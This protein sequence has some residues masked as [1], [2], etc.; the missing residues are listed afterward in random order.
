MYIPAKQY[1]KKD[2]FKS[3]V[4]Y[5]Y[6]NYSE[7]NAKKIVNYFIGSFG[8]KRSNIDQGCIT[9][10]FQVACSL[11]FQ[12]QNDH[13][14]SIDTMN[15]LHFVR[16][17]N[18]AKLYNNGLS[19]HR[20]IICGGIINLANLYYSIKSPTV[21]II[22]FNTDSIMFKYGRNDNFED[23]SFPDCDNTILQTIGKIRQEPWKIKAR[24]IFTLED[25]KHEV[26]E[27]LKWNETKEED[28]SNN[29]LDIIESKSSALISGMPGCGKT[30]LIKSIYN[31][32]TDL[33]LSF[34]NSA[35]T[36]T[37][38]RCYPDQKLYTTN[39]FHTFD[40]FFHEHLTFEQKL[41][42]AS[43]YDRILVDEYSMVPS[44][45]MNL[46]NIIKQK[47]G[48]TLY[49]FGDSNQCL[50]VEPSGIIYDYFNTDTFLNMCDGNN[51]ICSYKEEY[52]RYDMPL[53][54]VLDVIIAS[55]NV[56]LPSELV[57]KTEQPLY[58]NI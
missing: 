8:T 47:Y 37:L 42:H 33:I 48:T 2:I 57:V 9:S 30:E 21:N 13:K 3:F 32:K 1:I 43:K 25:R 38:S 23:L 49:F 34:T 44:K 29:F 4:E 46:L 45:Y 28:C 58:I 14:V 12:Y 36:N 39:N 40:S 27:A 56:R 7:Y 41:E 10:C 51:F 35:V 17:R 15:D 54:Q 22:A 18:E 55:N 16:V 5:I 6:T 11:L 19:I 52:S 20:H 50:Q 31:D 24:S 26:F 53:K